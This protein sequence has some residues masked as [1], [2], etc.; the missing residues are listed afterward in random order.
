MRY[1]PFYV[2]STSKARHVLSE[3]EGR[4]LPRRQPP[5]P[6]QGDV[7]LRFDMT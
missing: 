3:A 1:P 6:L 4:Y 2:I 7:S 5:R